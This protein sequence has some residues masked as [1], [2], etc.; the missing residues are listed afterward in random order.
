MRILIVGDVHWNQYCSIVRKQGQT[1]SQRLHNLIKSVQWAEDYAMFQ[2][3]DEV[4]YLGDFFDK[5]I[6]NSEEISAL[7]RFYMQFRH[8]QKW[9]LF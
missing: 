6:I 3:A 2:Q 8:F 7:R 5:A 4:V 1:Y 9:H